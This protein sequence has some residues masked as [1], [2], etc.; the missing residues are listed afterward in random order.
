MLRLEIDEAEHAAQLATKAAAD[1]AKEF[2]QLGGLQQN[3]DAAREAVREAEQVVGDA[4]A[5]RAAAEE[6]LIS[7]DGTIQLQ[8]L[9][10]LSNADTGGT[11]AER[12]GASDPFCKVFW[13]DMATPHAETEVYHNEA[14]V[15][16]NY[17][18]PLPKVLLAGEDA[19]TRHM[20]E[21]M[22]A[23]LEVGPP[24]EPGIGPW[25]PPSKNVL[26][27][28]VWDH[29]A[30]DADEFLG[31]VTIES[32]GGDDF[33]A[34][35]QD[36]NLERSSRHSSRFVGGK[37]SLG[38]F[39]VFADQA[40]AAVEETQAAESRAVQKLEQLRAARDAALTEF[41]KQHAACLETK[42]VAEARRVAAM[43]EK[44]DCIRAQARLETEQK[45]ARD[46]RLAAGASSIMSVMSG[47]EGKAAIER[48]L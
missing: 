13:Q 35:K 44:Q 42:R 11:G 9:M 2:K 26:K 4:Q 37:I 47:M 38:L 12:D 1:A 45:E 43:K 34:I 18:V 7:P 17:T 31:Q 28:E 16:M 20:R 14:D 46:A 8:R 23:G 3:V 33:P 41:E 40:Q 36:Y 22:H 30:T 25:A 27:I 21:S 6:G 48:H 19:T 10:G 24:L 32:I 5:R 39:R 15:Q 29:D